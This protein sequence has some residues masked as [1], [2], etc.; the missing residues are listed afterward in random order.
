MFCLP[1]IRQICLYQTR[2][3]L[4]AAAPQ[5]GVIRI[6]QDGTSVHWPGMQAFVALF[7]HLDHTTATRAKVEALV[8]Y[9]GGAEPADAAWAPAVLLGKQRRRLITGR[10]LRQICLEESPLPEWLFDDCYAQVGDSAETIALLWP[11]RH[12]AAGHS[13]PLHVWPL[14][15]WMRSCCPRPPPWS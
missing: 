9:F 1:G 11:Q 5:A 8:H 14:H 13:G 15:V 12:P 6:R 3:T 10:R 2:R 7:A 4:R